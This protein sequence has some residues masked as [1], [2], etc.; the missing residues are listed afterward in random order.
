MVGGEERTNEGKPSELKYRWKSFIKHATCLCSKK[1]TG[2]A[3]P[4]LQECTGSQITQAQ[5]TG[6]VGLSCFVCHLSVSLSTTIHPSC[7]RPLI[8]SLYLSINSPCFQK[9]L[10]LIYFF[11]FRVYISLFVW[12][13][14][15]SC[16][17]LSP[18]LST[19]PLLPGE[20]VIKTVGDSCQR[21]WL[22]KLP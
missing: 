6:H 19:C 17:V 15:Y 4:S 14:C 5:W 10:R 12:K 16:C 3:E 9:S 1:T 7:Y 11:P 20:T 18:I 8:P 21:G 2:R 13:G 22:P